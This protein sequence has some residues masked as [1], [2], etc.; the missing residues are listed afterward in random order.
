[1]SLIHISNHDQACIKQALAEFTANHPNTVAQEVENNFINTCEAGVW[2]KGYDWSAE[3]FKKVH[4]NDPIASFIG[5]W[6]IGLIGEREITHNRPV[7]GS[8]FAEA[9]EKGSITIY[10][11]KA[12][13]AEQYN[14]YCIKEDM[15]DREPKRIILETFNTH[16]VHPLIQHQLDRIF[17]EEPKD[18]SDDCFKAPSFGGCTLCT[19]NVMLDTNGICHD[20]NAPVR[21]LESVRNSIKQGAKILNEDLYNKWYGND[22]SEIKNIDQAIIA[23]LKELSE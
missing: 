22:A 17:P 21:R 23:A 15:G 11:D 10:D 12:S 6:F 2:I 20:C 4:N 7:R 14:I 8:H 19:K 18:G 1:M 13:A 5:K 9:I 16:T 3:D